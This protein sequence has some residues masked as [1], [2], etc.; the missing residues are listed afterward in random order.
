MRLF[1]R[2]L[3]V[4]TWAVIFFSECTQ[5][6]AALRPRPLVL[7]RLR[8]R[9]DQANLGHRTTRRVI[10][11]APVHKAPRLPPC[12]VLPVT[13]SSA[14]SR[15][16]PSPAPRH[17]GCA[18]RTPCIAPFPSPPQP[19][20]EGFSSAFRAHCASNS[21]LCS[22]LVSADCL[23]SRLCIAHHFVDAHPAASNALSI[24]VRCI[25]FDNPRMCSLCSISTTLFMRHPLRGPAIPSRVV[26]QRLESVDIPRTVGV[27]FGAQL[28][29]F[30]AVK[31]MST[32]LTVAAQT[33]RTSPAVT[34]T[35]FFLHVELAFMPAQGRRNSVSQNRPTHKIFTARAAS[36]ATIISE[37]SDCSIVPSFA[38]R[39]NTA[40]SVG[41]NAVLV[42]NARKR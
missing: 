10:P 24:E 28:L 30:Y 4:V 41:E 27:Q 36:S 15:T 33:S 18:A 37:I 35:G 5:F 9:V 2:T 11:R 3:I 1:A 22:P 20:S 39:D 6:G 25:S 14:S 26:R 32:P 12:S 23:L 31:Y 8:A 7:H 42:L 16:W 19:V 29:S 38:H 40:V 21:F 34:R 17:P 13:S